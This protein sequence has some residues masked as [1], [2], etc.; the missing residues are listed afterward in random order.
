MVDEQHSEMQLRL[1]ECPEQIRGP[2]DRRSVGIVIQ[3]FRNAGVVMRV[4]AESLLRS[5]HPRLRGRWCN[6]YRDRSGRHG[7]RGSKHP[8]RCWR[9]LVSA[10]TS[11]LIS[12]SPAL[13]TAVKAIRSAIPSM[14]PSATMTLRTSTRS[15]LLHSPGK[16]V[17]IA[18]STLFV[19]IMRHL[20]G[21]CCNRHKQSSTLAAT[22]QLSR[23]A[24]SRLREGGHP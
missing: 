4:D 23:S 3:H 11:A 10:R 17:L 5:S 7:S 15:P 1:F 14:S 9:P 18:C 2:D 19:T 21:D 13:P 16:Y 8:L 20:G 12:Y 6:R 22:C 24:R